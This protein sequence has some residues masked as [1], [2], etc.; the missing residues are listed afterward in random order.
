[1]Y[2]Q[3]T[4][5]D[6]TSPTGGFTNDTRKCNGSSG[7]MQPNWC[8]A[9]CGPSLSLL[10]RLAYSHIT[11]NSAVI[12]YESLGG[13]RNPG[14]SM[15]ATPPTASTFNCS[16]EPGGCCPASGGKCSAEEMDLTPLTKLQAGQ[17]KAML[18]YGEM[19]VHQAPIAF[20]LDFFQGWLPPR[21]LFDGQPAPLT[22]EALAYEP[23]WQ[24]RLYRSAF[25]AA[26][27]YEGGDFLANNLFKMA[28]TDY[29]DSSYF[30]N[31]DGFVSATPY[32][33][34][35]DTLLTDAPGW[36]LQ[37]YGTIVI[38][39][40]QARSGLSAELRDKLGAFAL[41]G[42]HLVIT[43]TPLAELT[44]GGATLL[45]IGVQP[46][47]SC[48]L[49]PAGTNVSCADGAH[50][51]EQ[52]AFELC[53]L[54]LPEK[55]VSVL[56]KLVPSDIVAAVRVQ[57][58]TGSVTILA[59]P[60]ALP[61]EAVTV[62][63]APVA[64]LGPNPAASNPLNETILSRANQHLHNPRPMLTHAMVVIDQALIKERL[65]EADED[66]RLAI[67]VN[68]KAAGEYTVTVTNPSVTQ[69]P[70]QLVSHVGPIQKVVEVPLDTQS[71]AEPSY[72]PMAVSLDSLGRSTATTI[73]GNDVRM[74][75]VSTVEPRDLDV[76]SDILPPSR[77][78]NRA[79]T[80]PRRIDSI[81]ESVRDRPTF[82]QN[83]DRV[84]VDWQ[85]IERT[86]VDAL[87]REAEWIVDTQN[88]K[89]TVDFRA[90]L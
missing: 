34:A 10:R 75:A 46:H 64:H 74:F 13:V 47:A 78:T 52:Y 19:G 89:I 36:L 73:A 35:V 38:G 39:D 49:V 25:G 48:Q 76:V 42:G 81:R 9:Q 86:D 84:V 30:W 70:L 61:H 54:A 17:R 37:R 8:S 51:T 23:Y 24:G 82:F 40:I 1:M 14:Y 62:F 3:T 26:I 85:H 5:V 21:R 60:F 15:R 2:K 20:M 43:F 79:L 44:M 12:L 31:E 88:L 33:D 66:A 50:I 41:A 16:G 11:Y 80:L 83:F 53:D 56:A 27:P 65:F 6:N 72:V 71:Y 90:P 32:G 45:G 68:R 59:S 7:I 57:T 69:L 87:R 58:G 28:F 67:S 22:I 4:Q 18:A 63:N 55:N 77:P 29:E